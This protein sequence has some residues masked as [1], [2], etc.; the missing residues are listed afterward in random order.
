RDRRAQHVR[1]ADAGGA[2]LLARADLACVVR[3]RRPVSA[4]HVSQEQGRA[5]MSYKAPVRELQFV[6]HELIDDSRLTACPAHAEYSAELAD[7]I[8]EEAARFAEEVLAPINVVGDR[9]G[10]R[11]TPEG[12][13]MP[14]AFKQAYEKFVEGGWPQLRAPQEH[15]GQGAPMLLGTAVEE[16]WGSANLS[17]KLCPMLTQGAVDALHRCGSAQQQALWLPKMVT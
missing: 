3:C 5:K 12:V 11:W 6:L 10:A 14:D 15:G 7:S 13:R 9:E 17:F 16:L 1:R 4:Q 2:P 8:L